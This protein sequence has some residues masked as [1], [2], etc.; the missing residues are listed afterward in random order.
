MQKAV[1]T[2]RGTRRHRHF[3][4]WF[5]DLL[6]ILKPCGYAFEAQEHPTADSHSNL[7]SRFSSLDIEES[8][9]TFLTS[10]R[11]SSPRPTIL[12]H[13]TRYQNLEAQ[14]RSTQHGVPS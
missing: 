4:N 5:K 1:D 11:P 3:N 12:D 6:S 7:N 9:L 8:S 10:N 2:A 14:L 13:T